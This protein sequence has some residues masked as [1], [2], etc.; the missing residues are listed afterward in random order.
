MIGEPAESDKLL[1]DRAAAIP[2]YHQIYLQLRDE[3]LTGQRPFGS[4]VPTEQELSAMFDVSRITA[5]RVLTELAQ[6]HFV[7]RRR[8]LGTRVSFRSPAKPIEANIDQAVDALVEFGRGSP[9]RVIEVVEEPAPRSVQAALRLD[10][11][12]KV[13]RAVRIRYQ[14]QDPL[15]YVVSYVPARLGFAVTRDSLKEKPILKLLAEADCRASH[16]EQ[17]I[18]AIV[19]DPALAQTLEIE[20][21]SPLLRIVRT[22]F[23]QDGRPFLLTFAHYRSDRFNVKVDLNPRALAG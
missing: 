13:I 18:G 4:S 23:D 12:E 3:I 15:G 17:T 5:R 14:D 20:P 9:V 7:E 6:Q 11:E 2:L 8:R 22:V 10:P 19:A 1:I 21:R 16:G